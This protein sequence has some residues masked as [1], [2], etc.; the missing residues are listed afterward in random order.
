M[1]VRVAAVAAVVA[2]VPTPAGGMACSEDAEVQAVVVAA[3]V[4]AS[5]R[6]L[7]TD[8][9]TCGPVTYAQHHCGTDNAEQPLWAP[10]E[11]E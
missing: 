2:V 10:N 6:R 5:L 9:T 11:V 4:A 8:Q 7:H 3:A 1:Q